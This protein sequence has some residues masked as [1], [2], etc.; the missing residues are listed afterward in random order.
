MIF[1][2]TPLKGSFTINMEPK[3]DKRGF[4]SRFFCEKEFEQNNLNT[5]W[6]QINN[7]LS[8][9]KGTLRGL[10]FQYPPYS[11]IKLIRCIKGSIWDVIVDIRNNSSTYGKWFGAELNES[12]RTMMYVPKG[13]AHGFISLKSNSEILYLVSE[14][15]NQINEDTLLWNDSEVNIEW[16]IEHNIISEKDTKGKKLNQIKS[17]I[18]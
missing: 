9:E 8:V 2:E 16:P 3:K 4:F 15:Y 17:V 10:H 7:S 1:K 5:N 18:L 14:Y 11:E 13:F 6:V 12:N